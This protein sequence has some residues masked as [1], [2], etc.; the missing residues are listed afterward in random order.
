M[1]PGW[2]TPSLPRGQL[3]TAVRR[4]RRDRRRAHRVGA[5]SP[6]AR[7]RGHES[8]A[9]RACC[10]RSTSP[11]T[12][13]AAGE[14]ILSL[15]QG[16]ARLAGGAAGAP[17][18]AQGQRARPGPCRSREPAE[19]AER[20]GGD[21]A[22][23]VEV[24]DVR[25]RAQSQAGGGGRDQ[26]RRRAGRATTDLERCRIESELLAA[27]IQNA[28]ARARSAPACPRRS[29]HDI[30]VR[31]RRDAERAPGP[32]IRGERARAACSPGC[33]PAKVFRWREATSWRG[34]ADLST[35]KV[36]ATISDVH[37][38]QIR[39]G[40]AGHGPR[41]RAV[42]PGHGGQGPSQGGE[43]HRAAGGRAQAA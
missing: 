18:R 6:R 24:A 22:A 15:D 23:G 39:A 41:R 43:R 4:A 37:A 11:A 31:E 28:E 32:G 20:R 21:Q 16:E 25:G 29:E 14:P 36:E 2:V 38:A 26:W 35:F 13:C 19:R 17:G 10:R 8:R 27:A 1:L 34:V 40:H 33:S 12:P 7:V 9:R 42:P 30:L 3:R 5:G